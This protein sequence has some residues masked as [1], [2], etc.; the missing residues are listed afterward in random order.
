[1]TDGSVADHCTSIVQW[2]SV[3]GSPTDVEA[4]ATPQ[5]NAPAAGIVLPGMQ[6]NV[7]VAKVP[8]GVSPPTPRRLAVKVSSM[9]SSPIASS[10][11][12]VVRPPAAYAT[13]CLTLSAAPEPGMLTASG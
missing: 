5:T 3:I 4:E 2:A 11:L 7:T 9:P 12:V 1:M 13:R 8:A 6:S 10:S